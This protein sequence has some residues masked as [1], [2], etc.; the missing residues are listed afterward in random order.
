MSETS[1]SPQKRGLDGLPCEIQL[2][3]CTQLCVHCSEDINKFDRWADGDENQRTL[4]ALSQ[5]SHTFHR[6]AQPIAFHRFQQIPT[7]WST[8]AFVKFARTLIDRPDLAAQV[9]ELCQHCYEVGGWSTQKDFNML[10]AAAD[11]L[12]MG[13]EDD[14]NFESAEEEDLSAGKFCMELLIALLPNL[15]T[16][17]LMFEDQGNYEQTTYTY[18]QRRLNKLGSDGTLKHLR[19]VILDTEENWG[20]F[21]S[22][23]A[24]GVLHQVAPNLDELIIR[25]NKGFES[26]DVAHSNL[27]AMF[28]G[29]TQS[30]CTLRLD[31]CALSN[32]PLSTSFLDLLTRHAPKLEHFSYRSQAPYFGEG[33]GT[34]LTPR[35]MIKCLR[36]LSGTLKSI[37]IDLTD[38]L[39]DDEQSRLVTG[40]SLAMFEKLE[41]L[42]L[43]EHAFCRHY[44]EG[45]DAPRRTANTCL[46]DLVPPTLKVLTVRVYDDCCLWPDLE[47]LVSSA[48]SKFPNLKK[49]IVHTIWRMG[50]TATYR[51]CQEAVRA[52]GQAFQDFVDSTHLKLEMHEHRYWLPDVY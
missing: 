13:D 25:H 42:R 26:M 19:R 31:H 50:S 41:D 10:K 11:R 3:I 48:S 17:Y 22:I 1:H 4:L 2:Q 34:H 16:L 21:F 35:E 51:D 45:P 20:F 38:H 6:L 49:I 5:T 33:L 14:A 27:G 52:K 9:K 46:T 29:P 12:G 37:D 15:E 47:E 39:D 43:D 7:N 28:S 44:I 36:P 23:P 18:L 24:V 30:L 8:N 32:D 40:R